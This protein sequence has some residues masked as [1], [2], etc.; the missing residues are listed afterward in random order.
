MKTE[1]EMS[2][3]LLR[4]RVGREGTRKYAKGSGSSGRTR[5]QRRASGRD[6]KDKES[7]RT[8]TRRKRTRTSESIDDSLTGCE[9]QRTRGRGPH[10]LGR[11]HTAALE[12]WRKQASRGTYTTIAAHGTQPGATR[13]CVSPST[14]R[15]CS[16]VRWKCPPLDHARGRTRER[17]AQPRT[18]SAQTGPQ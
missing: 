2:N 12:T 14:R 5:V 17:R 1:N 8:R 10:T 15:R 16:V 18:A 13:S 7:T 11:T 6:D 9:P 4:S 3:R